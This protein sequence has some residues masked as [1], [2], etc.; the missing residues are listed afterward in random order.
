MGESLGIANA[1]VYVRDSDG[2]L[3]V[4][5]AEQSAGERKGAKVVPMAGHSIAER[6]SAAEILLYQ[7]LV[8]GVSEVTVAA[9]AEWKSKEL[10]Y[11]AA[12]GYGAT[13]EVVVMAKVTSGDTGYFRIKDEDGTI[14]GAEQTVVS[15]AY[16]A[17]TF[18]WLEEGNTVGDTLSIEAK[19]TAAG[20][21]LA[22]VESIKVKGPYARPVV[23][24]SGSSYIE[25]LTV[26][27]DTFGF[28]FLSLMY[29]TDGADIITL[30]VSRDASTWHTHTEYTP[31]GAEEAVADFTIGFRYVRLVSA[32]ST[33]KVF[34]LSAKR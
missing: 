14:V 9:Y 26:V 5:R 28:P 27:L 13:I 1:V 29:D 7:E 33:S 8:S 32:A 22:Y 24:N 19:V 31:G 15:T 17:L 23:E 2:N 10:F 21:L 20:Q 16:T 11:E 12:I 3:Q 6:Y 4:A 34:W 25:A 30:Q 18:S